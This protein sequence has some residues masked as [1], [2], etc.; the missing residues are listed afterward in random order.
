MDGSEYVDGMKIIP[1]QTS[2]IKTIIQKKKSTVT[3]LPLHIKFRVSLLIS[4]QLD[5]IFHLKACSLILL[6]TTYSA[7]Y[8]IG[9]LARKY[10]KIDDSAINIAI[11]DVLTALDFLVETNKEL[12]I[13]NTLYIESPLINSN[14]HPLQHCK[15][16]L[17]IAQQMSY[18]Y[19]C[20]VMT[21]V[22]F[23]H[24]NQMNNIVEPYI[25][26]NGKRLM[27]LLEPKK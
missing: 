19:R 26:V 22:L 1:F 15:K 8:W 20:T 16:F 6:D 11:I 21:L 7:R 23:C 9:M 13:P 5:V 14:I 3:P 27:N 12:E 18:N 24:K 17:P 25:E 4:A 10:D 2:E